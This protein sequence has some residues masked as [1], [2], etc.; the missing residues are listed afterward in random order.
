[1]DLTNYWIEL[2]EPAELIKRTE[3]TQPTKPTE[4]PEP[5]GLTEPN[6]NDG[7]KKRHM[8]SPK[9]W[10][11]GRSVTFNIKCLQR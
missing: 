8:G 5:T 7:R 2:V 6:W 9:V 1:M 3:P 11:T 4:L 10:T